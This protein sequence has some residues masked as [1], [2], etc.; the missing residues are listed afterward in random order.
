MLA[1]Q[2][3]IMVRLLVCSVIATALS[4]AAPSGAKHGQDAQKKP[5]ATQTQLADEPVMRI[6]LSTDTRAA[7]ISTTAQLVKVSDFGNSQ[8]LD[9]TR[10]RVESRLL[11]AT[12]PATENIEIVV[13]RSLSRDDSV[14][15][16]DSVHELADEEPTAVAEPPDKWRVVVVK[17]SIED[18]EAAIAKLESA[19]F[20]ATTAFKTDTNDAMM[21]GD[22]AT[23]SSVTDVRQPPQKVASPATTNSGNTNLIHPPAST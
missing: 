6:A 21:P 22:K 4:L 2:P 10:V 19:G 1:E 15:L 14:R 17:H 18:A 12:K 16:I 5:A 3:P 8:P 13:A 11:S 23:N 20:D 7:T 9:T